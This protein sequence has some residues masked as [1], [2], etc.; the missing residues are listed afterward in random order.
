MIKHIQAIKRIETTNNAKIVIYNTNG[1]T[2]CRLGPPIGTRIS[3]VRIRNRTNQF[4]LYVL[5]PLDSCKDNS[6][7]LLNFRNP[8]KAEL[9]SIINQY[10]STIAYFKS[11]E[12][13]TLSRQI[14]AQKDKSTRIEP[15]SRSKYKS[16][17]TIGILYVSNVHVP[18]LWIGPSYDA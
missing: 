2:S 1:L 5:P 17:L 4:L 11:I 3:I 8:Q 7:V 10:D 18:F 12:T 9:I 13:I 6:T 15:S 14:S 16:K